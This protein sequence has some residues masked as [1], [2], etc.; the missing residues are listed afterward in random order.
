M[1]RRV[2]TAPCHLGEYRFLVREKDLEF[3]VAVAE[4]LAP[5]LDLEQSTN[6]LPAGGAMRTKYEGRYQEIPVHVW[7]RLQ[8]ER[9]LGR[10]RRA[11]VAR[12]AGDYDCEETPLA[13]FAERLEAPK[14]KPL[15]SAGVFV[16]KS[17]R[18]R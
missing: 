11:V 9:L 4:V 6:W 2:P 14:P 13:L 8:V 12:H 16:R 15:P 3:T 7:L 1:P 17:D 10:N 18:A 5:E